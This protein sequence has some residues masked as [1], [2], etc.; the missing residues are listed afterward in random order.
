M[1]ELVEG[2]I[3]T[4]A[5]SFR[6]GSRNQSLILD[7]DDSTPAALDRTPS[8]DVDGER[9]GSVTVQEEDNETQDAAPSQVSSGTSFC[10]HCIIHYVTIE[11]QQQQAQPTAS[12][13]ERRDSSKAP[14][15]QR[16]KC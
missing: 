3:A 8:D 5:A 10:L 16:I 9:S 6:A 7:D 2:I 13:Q 14:S 1:Q 11:S 12:I 15:H 4:G